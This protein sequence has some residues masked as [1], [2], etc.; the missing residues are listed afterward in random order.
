MRGKF[1]ISRFSPFRRVFVFF[2]QKAYAIRWR[3]QRQTIYLPFLRRYF[4]G[5]FQ[6]QERR[7]HVCPQRQQ[8]PACRSDVQRPEII[9]CLLRRYLFLSR[10]CTFRNV[11][12]LTQQ[13]TSDLKLYFFLRFALHF[14]RRKILLR[15]QCTFR[16]VPAFQKQKTPAAL[17][18][19]TVNKKRHCAVF[20]PISSS[21]GE[22]FLQPS[23]L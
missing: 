6:C 23:P 9:L 19:E 4:S 12:T 20:W 15:K 17:I 21:S 16:C 3:R 10:Q 7:V 14:L 18:C 2:K 8:T 13:K 22:H 1:F 5:T 11:F